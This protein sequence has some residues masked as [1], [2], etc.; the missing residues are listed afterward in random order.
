[1]AWLDLWGACVRRRDFFL[2]ILGGSASAWPLIV[3]AQ[4]PTKV[5]GLL[6]PGIPHLFDAFK[7]RMSRLGYIDGQNITYLHL[8]A[9]GKSDQIPALASQ[10][11]SQNVDLIVTAATLPTRSVAA[12]TSRIPIVFAALGDAVSTGLIKSLSR[13]GGNLTGLSF[14]NTEISSKRLEL[15]RDLFPRIQ[16]IAVLDDA[17]TVRAFF[18]ATRAAA[19]GLGVQLQLLQVSKTADFEPAFQSAVSSQA[20]AINVLASAFFNANRKH[21]IDLAAKYRLP[22]MYETSEYVRDG[23]LISYGPSLS[24]LFERA[25]IYAD[26]IL[27]GASP[28][29]LPVE[30]PA[31]FELIFNLKTAKALGLTVSE[32]FLQ[33]ADEVIE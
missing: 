6:D 32:S 4:Q 27:K 8:S 30:Q 5:I 31:K 14:L 33:R 22:A 18:E 29:D 3:Y 17:N 1:M 23:G 24:D 10:L 19:A 9:A 11:V 28:S 26:K 2:G 20:E 13:P 7:G 25:A 16:R 15:L 21:L 12:A